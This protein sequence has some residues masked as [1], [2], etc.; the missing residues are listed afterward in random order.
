MST[1]N[2]YQLLA[3]LTALQQRHSRIMDMPAAHYERTPWKVT[4][5][6]RA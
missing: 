1:M 4:V 5:R 2:G 3:F 6:P